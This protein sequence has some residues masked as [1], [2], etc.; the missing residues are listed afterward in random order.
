MH[1]GGS[2][3]LAL[4]ALREFE[5]VFAMSAFINGSWVAD[6]LSVVGNL[7]L[8]RRFTSS[9]DPLDVIIRAAA[10]YAVLADR[11]DLRLGVEYV[12]QD[13][14][15]VVESEEAEGGAVHLFAL[16]ATSILD[17]RRLSL[18][19]AP[20]VVVGVGAVGFGGRFTASYR[21]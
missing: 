5:C 8:E 14:E 17:G 16:S 21:F 6:R 12:G 10:N 3:G 19:V 9:A 2:L 7:Q 4:W 13:L 20:G 1:D 18:G 15:D 11:D